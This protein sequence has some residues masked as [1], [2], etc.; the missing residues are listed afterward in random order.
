[1]EM[2]ATHKKKSKNNFTMTAISIEEKPT[3]IKKEDYK[4]MNFGL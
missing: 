3:E 2:T 1:M 4:F